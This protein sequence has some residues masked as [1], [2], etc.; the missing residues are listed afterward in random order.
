MHYDYYTKAWVYR[1]PDMQWISD[2]RDCDP[3]GCYTYWNQDDTLSY[4]SYKCISFSKLKYTEG[5]YGEFDDYQTKFTIQRNGMY[6]TFDSNT[7]IGPLFS[8][9]AN[10]DIDS[11]HSLCLESY[12]DPRNIDFDDIIDE[13]WNRVSVY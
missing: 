1:M 6:A 9:S 7:K 11:M 2:Y 10:K 4:N 13:T 8:I 12:E 3:L 5:Y